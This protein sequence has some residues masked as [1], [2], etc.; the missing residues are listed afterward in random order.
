MQDFQMNQDTFNQI[1]II[2]VGQGASGKDYF[3]SILKNKGYKCSI[4]YTSRPP[5]DGE[6]DGKDYH[7]V[8]REQFENLIEA[9][10]FLEHDIFNGW[11]YGTPIPSGEDSVFI[12]TPR[13]VSALS[14]ELRKQCVVIFINLP[15]EIRRERLSK[16]SDADSIERRLDADRKDFEGFTDFDV[17]ITNVF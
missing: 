3:K 12:M 10:V 11:Y 2:L 1:K 16:R 13:G 6:E 8:T 15:E 5:R 9:N 4:S 17:E 14:E 7:F